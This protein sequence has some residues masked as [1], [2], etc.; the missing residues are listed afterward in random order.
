MKKLY[1]TVLVLA[2]LGLMLL[3]GCTTNEP[4]PQT[5][6]VTNYATLV[7]ELRTSGATVVSAGTVDQPFFTVQ[8]RVITV[9]NG[10]VQVFEYAD[11]VTA[12]T[13]ASLVSADGSS[14]GTS[15]ASWIATPHFYKKG[16]VL[17]LYVGDDASTINALVK[18]L[19]QQFAGR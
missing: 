14:I 8:G 16:R 4:G 17:V 7:D 13:E 5:G 15:M 9:N 12:D 18:V 19:G 6:I 2:L 1:F 11:A 3:I 10:D